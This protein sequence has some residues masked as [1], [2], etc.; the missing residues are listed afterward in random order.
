M[1]GQLLT[2]AFSRFLLNAA[3]LWIVLF[4][5]GTAGQAQEKPTVI[6]IRIDEK[7]DRLTPD[8]DRDIEWIHEYTVTLSAKNAISEVQQNIFA[9]S[10]LHPATARRVA[11]L[12]SDQQRQLVLGQNNGKVEWQVLGP[13]KLRRIGAQG[14]SLAMFDISIDEQNNCH[15]A[16]RYL[17]QLGFA[18]TIGIRAGTNTLEHFSLSRLINASCEVAA[19]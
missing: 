14:Q 2:K 16:V 12:A 3:G 9:G 18:D 8:V 17:K 7:H 5:G 11:T 19:N 1:G 10:P 15:I 6:H 4:A 13:K